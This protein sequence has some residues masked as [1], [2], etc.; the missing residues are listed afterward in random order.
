[1]VSGQAFRDLPPSYWGSVWTENKGF[2]LKNERKA[3]DLLSRCIVLSDGTSGYHG[4]PHMTYYFTGGRWRGYP[5]PLSF[6]SLL[7]AFPLPLFSFS[8][9]LSLLLLYLSLTA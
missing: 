1:M 6:C 9:F 4:G 8:F 7:C 2:V 3:F 5:Y